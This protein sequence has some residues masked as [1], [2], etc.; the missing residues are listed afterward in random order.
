MVLRMACPTKRKGSNNWYF[1]RTIPADVKSILGRLPKAQRPR[2]WYRTHISISLKTADR[3]KAKARCPE[4]AAEVERRIAALR[5]GP[6]SL[7][8]KQI[9]A[10]SGELYKGITQALEEDPIAS[11]AQWLRVAEVNEAAR[12]GEFG[13]LAIFG[14]RT[15]SSIHAQITFFTG[16]SPDHIHRAIGF[17]R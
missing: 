5:E 14:N 8:H 6:K 17:F 9:A 3:D 4:I 10:L 16:T 7:S 13:T 2:N 1:R 15:A 12:R 11:A